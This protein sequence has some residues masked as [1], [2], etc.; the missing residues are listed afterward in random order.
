MTFVEL[1]YIVVAHH[2]L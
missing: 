2:S 1:A